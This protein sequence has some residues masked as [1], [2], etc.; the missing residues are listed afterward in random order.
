MTFLIMLLHMSSYGVH[1]FFL[2]VLG[3]MWKQ[4]AETTNI[5]QFATT[6][7]ASVQKNDFIIEDS[8]WHYHR[9]CS[10]GHWINYKKSIRTPN[11]QYNLFI[12]SLTSVEL[13]VQRCQWCFQEIASVLNVREKRMGCFLS[14]VWK[15]KCGRMK[16]ICS[17]PIFNWLN[18]EVKLYIGTAVRWCPPWI[19]QLDS[20]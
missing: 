9:W 14:Q 19:P 18:A 7:G 6:E 15:K 1:R 8:L 2:P 11:F 13:W 3:L 4:L 12:T 17:T 10:L 20:I 5:F 16:S